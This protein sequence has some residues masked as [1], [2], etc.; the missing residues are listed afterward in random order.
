MF[1]QPWKTDNDDDDDYDLA[2]RLGAYSGRVID[3]TEA[4]PDTKSGRHVRD[5]LLRSGTAVG[6]H[7]AEA[8]SAQS[9]DDFIHK[10]ALAAKEV[11]ESLHWLHSIQNARAFDGHVSDLIV[12]ADELVAILFSSLQTARENRDDSKGA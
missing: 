6:A 10:I 5:Q 7:Y 11:R 8:C 2:P 4:L 12:E 1:E 9:Q 3:L